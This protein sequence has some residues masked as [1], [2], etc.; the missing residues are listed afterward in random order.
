MPRKTPKI[1]TVRSKRMVRRRSS[2]KS[3][4]VVVQQPKPSTAQVLR[5]LRTKQHLPPST[6]S[7]MS[8][9]GVAASYCLPHELPP[10][11]YA[12][13]FA[14][15]PTAVCNPY[16]LRAQD[17]TQGQ[18]SGVPAIPNGQHFVAVFRNVLRALI[19]HVPNT[20]NL[21]A[22]YQAY[23]FDEGSWS[24]DCTVAD[25]YSKATIP[26]DPNYLDDIYSGNSGHAH[27]H[28]DTLYVGSHSGRRG[29]WM[30]ANA[31]HNATAVFTF[32]PAFNPVIKPFILDGDDWSPLAEVQAASATG[33]VTVT[34]SGYYAFEIIPSAS[35]NS[36][37]S[38][39]VNSSSDFMGHL[40][41]PYISRKAASVQAV[42]TNAVSVMLT[43]EA[44]ALNASGK[45]SGFQTPAG[46]SWMN[47]LGTDCFNNVAS[48][49]NA[50]TR[51]L[52]NGTYG[53]LKPSAIEDF[54]MET[55]FTISGGQVIGM[56]YDLIPKR[57]YLVVAAETA[58]TATNVYPGGDCYLTASWGLEFRTDDV[59]Y[60]CIP[61]TLTTEDFNRQVAAIRYLQQWH[62]NP[63]HFS[64]IVNFF[65]SAGRKTLK[66]APSLLAAISH[67]PS[68]YSKSL[69]IASGIAEGLGQL[70]L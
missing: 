49:Q 4:K 61:P 18:T 66:Y 12:G 40:P 68:P 62:D 41:V 24:Y 2:A 46:I 1:K 15:T 47:Y 58:A 23:F 7:I 50:S 13:T 51:Q 38:L 54:D 27:P 19:T 69:G 59:W 35:I 25:T 33:T 32:G 42:R 52:I 3:V 67:I 31:A 60:V 64:D 5:N 48:S 63:L 37:F 43:C 9:K 14:S 57:D 29:I 10:V 55:P 53:F 39:I 36:W 34:K 65:K 20:S 22:S 8:M 28:G 70:I 6:S 11:R 56:D 44:S 26:V 21:T 16:Y 45:V 30:D 17:F